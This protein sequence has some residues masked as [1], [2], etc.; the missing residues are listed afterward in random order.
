MQTILLLL[1]ALCCSSLC[2]KNQPLGHFDFLTVVFFTFLTF[3]VLSSP[4]SP[5]AFQV[6]SH[7]L[8]IKLHC[9]SW[10]LWSS[11]YQ[12][13]AQLVLLHCPNPQRPQSRVAL[14]VDQVQTVC[15][16][17]S[18]VVG[19]GITWSPSPL[20]V[21]EVAVVLHQCASTV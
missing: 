2:E 8:K 15:K 14:V 18:N 9:L 21:V 13:L 4:S 7:L 19:T 11:S 12:G 20:L 5:S 6:S 10:S 16:N 1:K 3:T 17:V